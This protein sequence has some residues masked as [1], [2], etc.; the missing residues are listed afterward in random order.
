[1]SSSVSIEQVS[2]TIKAAL[3][4]YKDACKRFHS[5]AGALSTLQR[6]HAPLDRLQDRL[7]LALDSEGTRER[8][9]NIVI[10][11]QAQERKLLA[12]LGYDVK[13]VSTYLQN[14]GRPGQSYLEK[15]DIDVCINALFRYSEVFKL[16]L[17]KNTQCVLCI[18]CADYH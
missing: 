10:S 14:L 7:E 9:E 5:D 11:D 2:E 4:A 16:V 12:A 1:M 15:D 13:L 17:K 18:L 6:L 3:S 8:L